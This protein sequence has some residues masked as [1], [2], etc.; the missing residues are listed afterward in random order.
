MTLQKRS[1]RQGGGAAQDPAPRGAG[2][3]GVLRGVLV[4]LVTTLCAE[5]AAPRQG[6]G[7]EQ[8][9]GPALRPTLEIAEGEKPKEGSLKLEWSVEDEEG[10]EY[11]L[12]RAGTPEFAD[13]LVLYTGP[14]EASFRSG[15]PEGVHHFRVRARRAD[16]PWGP[17]SKSVTFEVTPYSLGVAVLM[18]CVGASL[19]AA[20]VGFLVVADRRVRVEE[21]K[22]GGIG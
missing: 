1:A 2:R 22:N 19:V 5:R 16:G 4:A 17:W 9:S 7:P 12:V 21:A 20:I 13:P 10:L 18:F 15:L 3:R 14:D 6:E 8:E 11:E